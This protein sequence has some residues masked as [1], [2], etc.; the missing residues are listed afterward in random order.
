MTW[1]Y[2]GLIAILAGFVLWNM[3]RQRRIAEQIAA[4]LV[5]GP[6]V[7]RILLIK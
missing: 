6:L 7:L 3:V 1:A 5:L 2:L 4:A